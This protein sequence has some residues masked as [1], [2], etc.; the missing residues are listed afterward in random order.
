FTLPR[1]E[2]ARPHRLKIHLAFEHQ[3]R[4]YNLVLE[5]TLVT[6]PQIEIVI[7]QE[8]VPGKP[9]ARRILVNIRNKTLPKRII[10]VIIHAQVPGNPDRPVA[11]GKIEPG[12]GIEPPLMFYVAD[13][14]KLADQARIRVSVQDPAGRIFSNKV[15]PIK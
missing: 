12:A 10:N 3:D 5:R 7:S 4:I 14:T 13:I 2:L 1:T 15:V 11:R 6:I 9:K 8:K